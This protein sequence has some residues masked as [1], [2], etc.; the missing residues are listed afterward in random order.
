MNRLAFSLVL[1]LVA[2][3]ANAAPG[4]RTTVVS[5]LGDELLVPESNH[6]DASV[7]FPATAPKKASLSLAVRCAGR[8]AARPRMLS[9]RIVAADGA[10]KELARIQPPKNGG[11]LTLDLTKHAALFAGSRTVR[12]LVDSLASKE[13]S[14]W[15]VDASLTLESARAKKAPPPRDRVASR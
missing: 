15:R 4:G 7:E 6:A 13:R 1:A 2:A 3:G 10:E 8:C 12:V 9:V 5:L 14:G 11:K